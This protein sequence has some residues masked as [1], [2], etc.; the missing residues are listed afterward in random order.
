MNKQGEIF[1][2]STLTLNKRFLGFLLL[3]LLIGT[4]LRISLL[5]IA[6]FVILIICVSLKLRLSKA[7]VYLLLLCFL[8]FLLSFFNGLFLKYKLVS[9]F[10]MVPFLVLMFSRPGPKS[11]KEADTAKLYFN[12]LAIIAFVNDITG[13]VQVIKR[14]ASD[15][16]FTGIYSV[17]SI[18]LNGLVIMNAILF[19]FYFCQYLDSKN[20]L[21]LM[22]SLFFLVSSVM[23]FYGAGLI[24]ITLAFILVFFRPSLRDILK[25]GLITV[26]SLFAVYWLLFF[27]KPKVLEYNVS[28][29]KKLA[30]FDVRHGPRKITSVYNYFVS[31]P[32]DPKDFVFGSGPGTFNSRSA[33]MVGSPSFFNSVRAIKSESQ[34]YYFRNYAYSLWNETNTSQALYQDGFRNQPFS[35]LLA[36]LGEYGLLFTFF[37]LWYYYKYYK[38]L[39]QL[40]LRAGAQPAYRRMSKFLFILLLGLLVIDNFYEYPEMMILILTGIKVLDI[41]ILKKQI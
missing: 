23:G 17:Y 4:F 11:L 26:I 35:S 30:S 12:S 34:P 9:L 31:Y 37:F 28:N 13:Y 25:T 21:T 29:L 22:V 15:D 3:A 10:S 16:N 19:F 2:N 18:S 41:E 38:D 40:S 36:F 33:F 20:R 6:P 7:L 24:V 8:S 14:T 1:Y 5:L 32:Q 27:L 39:S